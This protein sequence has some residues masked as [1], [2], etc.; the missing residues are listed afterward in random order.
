[1]KGATRDTWLVTARS[2]VAICE[3][4]GAVCIINDDVEIALASQAH[5]V[6]LGKL[7]LDW[8]E[9][10][11]RLGPGKIIG[12]TVNNTVDATRATAA[13]T[14]PEPSPTPS[15]AARVGFWSRRTQPTPVAA[16]APGAF[17][18]PSRAARAGLLS[19]RCLLSIAVAMPASAASPPPS[20]AARDGLW[21]LRR[22][23]PTAAAAMAPEA[24]PPRADRDGL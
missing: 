10:R 13:G 6:H 11:R 7:D 3:R 19:R 14:A 22:P 1:M 18:P 5:G 4:H 2:V 21:S 9:A 8:R 24:F 16:T 12:G 17:P 23:R 20:R 15:R